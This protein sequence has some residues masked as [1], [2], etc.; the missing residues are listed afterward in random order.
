MANQIVEQRLIDTTNRLL[1]KVNG[2]FDGSGQV[3]NSTIIDVST[4]SYALNTNG[5]V[6][7]GNTDVRS[8]YR[9]YPTSIKGFSTV[10]F[11]R[12]SVMGITT[13]VY[14]N[15]AL[16]DIVV[17]GNGWFSFDLTDAFKGGKFTSP[18][19]TANM[20]GDF[21][22]TSLGAAANQGFTLIIDARKE[23]QD[24]DFGRQEDGNSGLGIRNP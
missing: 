7:T 3:S 8:F 9:I 20:N 10:P 13:G 6:L 19:P 12:I 18:V 4:L 1:T 15:T 24:Y 16:N 23:P 5:Y 14:G 11:L 21:M 22:V 17:V 2:T